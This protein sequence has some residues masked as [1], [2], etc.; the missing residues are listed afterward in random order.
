L[1]IKAEN[2][3]NFILNDFLIERYYI[4]VG[5]F[6]ALIGLLN[7]VF[8]FIPIEYTGYIFVVSIVSAFSFGDVRREENIKSFLKLAIPYT[9]I[10]LV[11]L[12]S[13]ND[14]WHKVLDWQMKRNIVFQIND[15]FKSIPFNDAAFTRIFHP[16]LLTDFMKTI[17]ES[18]FVL[19]VII[20][21]YRAL[22]N[23]DFEKMIRYT[24][25]GHILQV[26]M[27]T[28]F[29]VT[30][31]IQNVWFVY[32]HADP[33]NR[34]MPYKEAAMST[35]NGLP[36]MHTSIAFAMFLLVLRERNKIFKWVWSIYCLLIIYST[37]Y[38]EIHW[39]IDVLVGLAFGFIA[40]KL[41][42][43]FMLMVKAKF[44]KSPNSDIDSYDK[45]GTAI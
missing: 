39:V 31:Y 13:G 10:I 24:L 15:L 45:I 22:L 1:E 33:L 30:F 18:G 6:I 14:I 28:P 9:I 21:F 20:P 17:Y 7:I 27:V 29:Y 41:V 12:I 32:G 16:Q 43:F 38:L 2:D 3:K 25:S 37:M 11:V 19:A 44:I 42:D 23:K 4:L 36:S 40:V 5:L 26:F 35:L 34:N 8:K